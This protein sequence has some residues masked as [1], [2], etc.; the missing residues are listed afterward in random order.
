MKSFLLSFLLSLFM[1]CI[2]NAQVVLDDFETGTGHF[3]VQTDYSGSTVGIWG[4]VPTIDSSTAAFG[5]KSLKIVLIDNPGLAVDWQVRFLSGIGNPSSN[6]NMAPK[7]YTGYWLKTDRPWVRTAPLIDAPA[8]GE[9]GDTVHVIGDNQW[10]LYQWNLGVDGQPF[11]KGFATG[12]DTISDDPTPTYDAIWFFCP[13]GS[14]TTIIY[15]DQVIWDSLGVIP[16]EL[17]SFTADMDK[18]QIMLRWITASETNNK[19]FEIH[20]RINSAPYETIAFIVGKGTSTNLSGYSYTDR[21]KETGIY[22][23]RLK[24][25][26]FDGSFKYS[27]EV[28]VNIAA[29][30]GQYALIQNFPNPFNPTTTIDYVIAQN[31]FVNLSIFN[32]LGEKVAELVNEVKESGNHSVVF[33]ASNLSSGTYIY[34]LTV[35]G[36]ILT[37]KMTLIK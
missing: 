18:D 31:G 27:K 32:L 29:L 19:G 25:I 36:N 28:S 17:V 23:Y 10:H 1:F 7:G 13:D 4:T 15:L 3:N 33:N 16:V 30:P 5:S 21:I 35:N 37:K 8:T 22:S 11:W 12:N 2:S 6:I 9:T 34:I 26:N 24:Q 20:R 14:D